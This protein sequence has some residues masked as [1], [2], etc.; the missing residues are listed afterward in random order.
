MK[1]FLAII[2]SAMILTS[3]TACN[4]DSSKEDASK[5]EGTAST[6]STTSNSKDNSSETTEP[7]TENKLSDVPMAENAGELL[8]TGLHEFF[9]ELDKDAY[10]LEINMITTTSN[11]SKI[12]IITRD[13]ES[14]SASTGESKDN[15]SKS[16]VTD[17]KGYVIDDEAKTVTWSEFEKD[18]AE[19]YTEYLAQLFYVTNIKMTS[20]GKEKF[21]DTEMDYEE[22]KVT[23]EESSTSS[24]S[25]VESSKVEEQFIRYYFDNKTFKGMKII[26]GDNY[27]ALMIASM[28]HDIPDG[29][30][31]IP[32]DY[33]LVQAEEYSYDID[34][35][36][37]T[38]SKDTSVDESTSLTASTESSKESTA[39][40]AE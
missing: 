22:Y 11:S 14:I 37:S 25:S 10:R 24:N 6:T 19:S 3:F 38:A 2:F 30:F 32:S 20:S 1:K 9:V 31:D 36:E 7:S 40:S 34:G 15:L 8:K 12:V 26:N 33:K 5:A 39:S 17:N 35:S 28:T 29:E 23:T 21:G 18:Y 16:I 13:G 27:Y 4:N